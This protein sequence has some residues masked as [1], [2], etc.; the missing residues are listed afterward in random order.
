MLT[1][2]GQAANFYA[3]FNI[4]Q[5]GDHFVCSSAIYGERSTSCDNEKLGIDVIRRPRDADEDFGCAPP[6]HTKA[7]F[8]ETISQSVARSARH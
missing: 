7:L 8:G 3:I 2:S 1:S 5:A 4:C 6:E